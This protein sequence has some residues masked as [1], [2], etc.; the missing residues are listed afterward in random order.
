MIA[1]NV[2]D[3]LNLWS[4]TRNDPVGYDESAGH[5]IAAR[6]EADARHI[7]ATAAGDEGEGPWFDERRSA[8]SYL[9][10]AA[11][12]ITDPGIVLSDFRNG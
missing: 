8:V 6:G 11:A 2:L 12:R 5:V 7:A 10:E 3:M 4:I 1:G 9:G